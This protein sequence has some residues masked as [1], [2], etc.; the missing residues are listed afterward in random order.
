MLAPQTGPKVIASIATTPPM[1]SPASNPFSF[2]PVATARMVVISPQVIAASTASAPAG[3]TPIAAFGR[4]TPASAGS[5]SS[6][7]RASAASV[8]PMHWAKT[9]AGTFRQASRRSI[10]NATVTAGF[11]CAPQIGP[12]VS[13]MQNTTSPNA[14]ATPACPIAPT[15]VA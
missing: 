5:P 10:A 9:Y 7:R 1:A 8:A 14:N 15:P 4:V 11:R 6:S 2:G 13:I 3:P 12:T